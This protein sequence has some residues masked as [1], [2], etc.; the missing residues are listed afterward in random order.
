MADD[1]TTA[2]R[3]DRVLL[4]GVVFAVLFAQVLLYP[5]IPELVSVLGGESA[6]GEGTWFLASRPQVR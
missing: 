4:A 1:G 3:R 6:L 2:A 5:G